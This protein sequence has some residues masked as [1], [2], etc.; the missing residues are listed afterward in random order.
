LANAIK[1]VYLPGESLTLRII[2]E[3]TDRGQGVG[4]LDDGTMVVV[5]N[6]G[7]FM[8]KDI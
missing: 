3:G 4:Y 8:N 7:R 1:N 5:E 2:H 6:G